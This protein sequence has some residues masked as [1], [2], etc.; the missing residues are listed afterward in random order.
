M[1][2]KGNF[3]TFSGRT[4]ECSKEELWLAISGKNKCHMIKAYWVENY[5]EFNF[6]AHD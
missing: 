6:K 4:A 3:D 2:L 5:A 1:V